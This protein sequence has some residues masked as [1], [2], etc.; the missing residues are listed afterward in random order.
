MIKRFSPLLVLAPL[1]LSCGSP[2]TSASTSLAPSSQDGSSSVASENSSGA[3]KA[4]TEKEVNV[5]YAN[6]SL[7][8]KTKVRFY[9]HTGET[10]YMPIDT[11]YSLLLKGRTDDEKRTKL[12][13]T[14]SGDVY[15]VA[16]TEGKATFDVKE[17][18]MSSDNF[19]FFTST[20]TYESG[21]NALVGSDGMPWMKIEKIEPSTDPKKTIVDFDDYGIDLLGDG[22]SLYLPLPTMQDIFSDTNIIT[23]LYNRK[24]IYVYKGFDDDMKN[25]G[26]DMYEPCLK[27]DLGVGY[28]TYLY[29]EMC[30]DYDVIL[31]RPTRSS[32][33][34]YYDLSQGLDHALES[35][36]LGKIVKQYLTDG[37][38]SGYATGLYLMG[39]LT[40]D[41]G[42]TN[43]SPFMGSMIDPETGASVSP[44]W[45][46]GILSQVSAN[47]QNLSLQGYEEIMDS[48]KSY[49]HHSEIRANRRDGLG[50]ASTGLDGLRGEE[51]YKKVNSTA[52]I[53]IDG[54]MNDCLNAE[55]W[56]KYYAGE[57]ML[58]YGEKKGGAVVSLFK[59]LQKA[60]ED[61]SVKNV[62]IDL[63]SNTGG[64][65][66]EMMY[67]VSLL[68]ENA[69]GETAVSFHNR[70]TDQRIKAKLLIDRNL[71][72]VFDEKDKELNLVKGK[73]VAVLM[74]Q[75]GFSC[76]G[77]SPIL[78][79]DN[80]LFTMGDI[81]GGGCCSIFYQHT[82]AGLFTTR[83]SGDALIDKR[84][85]KID[86][87]R[88]DSCD[89]KFEIKT[90]E[91]EG[92]TFLDY[93]AFFKIE[94]IERVLAEHF[95]A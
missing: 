65:L 38:A 57:G 42:H 66:D 20:K 30:F 54:Y 58:P 95:G 86:E 22:F 26:L 88:E 73:N 7:N 61:Q 17:N 5:Y 25:M 39:Q 60:Q 41:G 87:A 93:S 74:S 81:S 85:R 44:S 24:D 16:S 71:D 15:T 51:T 63:S 4:F 23:S 9:E 18:V 45:T 12:S 91:S 77:I 70:V 67:V 48:C 75:N 8:Q 36:P 11:Y 50:L 37:T 64:S 72:R 82:G 35:R 46:Q 29:N 53:F 78:L 43:V 62:V 34:R 27:T 92:K 69:V 14:V 56:K 1:L 59:G 79:H 83:S 55:E 52:F 10:P 21:Y 90:V 31:G 32:L 47:L 2:S 84:G 6:K 94:D 33:E 13:V 28:A 3:V 80:G 19:S 40:A 68:T 89:H 49:N 76:G